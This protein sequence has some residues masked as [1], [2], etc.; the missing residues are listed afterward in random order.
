LFVCLLF[1]YYYVCCVA[2]ICQCRYVGCSVCFGTCTAHW[3]FLYYHYT[4][5]THRVNGTVL[6]ARTPL[7]LPNRRGICRYILQLPPT[8]YILHTCTTPDQ[9]NNIYYIDYP[10][11][12]RVLYYVPYYSID[13]PKIDIRY[14]VMTTFLEYGLQ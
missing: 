11:Y 10:Y 12:V 4:S 2:I 3:F 13:I 1:I 5:T 6:M 7:F 8:S 9:N 14:N